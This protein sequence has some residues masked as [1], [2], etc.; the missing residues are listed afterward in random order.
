MS[1]PVTTTLC[2]GVGLALFRTSDPKFNDEHPWFDTQFNECTNK[3]GP[4][5]FLFN[6]STMEPALKG[7]IATMVFNLDLTAAE[8]VTAYVLYESV[9]IANMHQSATV[10]CVRLLM[11]TCISLAMKTLSDENLSTS[12]IAAMICDSG[13]QMDKKQLGRLEVAVLKSLEYR[14]ISSPEV[15]SSYAN[16]L[17]RVHHPTAALPNL[18]CV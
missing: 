4:T 16:Q 8:L 6:E 10:C 17:V 9:L 7:F 1:G 11:T 15:Y 5:L 12:L 18:G 3:F 14:I 13:F 2:N